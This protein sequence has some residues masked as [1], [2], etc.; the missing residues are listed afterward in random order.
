[1]D[2]FAILLTGIRYFIDLMGQFKYEGISL[3]QVAF[4]GLFLTLIWRFLLSPLFGV[5]GG[6]LSAGVSDV[7]RKFKK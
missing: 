3:L 6:S 5:N 4:L 7:V 2:I 1:M